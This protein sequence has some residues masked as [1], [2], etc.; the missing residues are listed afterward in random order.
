VVPSGKST[1]GLPNLTRVN[2]DSFDLLER[3]ILPCDT[4]SQARDHRG[5]RPRHVDIRM[6]RGTW[7]SLIGF[8]S[9]NRGPIRGH[10]VGVHRDTKAPSRKGPL[11]RRVDPRVPAK[12][13][14]T[15][16]EERAKVRRT[17]GRALGSLS[18]P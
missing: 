13:E 11:L 2:A 7:E 6:T 1:G 17:S 12:A 14:A 5:L 15:G 10:P 9:K 4:A 8:L 3:S 18:G 16:T